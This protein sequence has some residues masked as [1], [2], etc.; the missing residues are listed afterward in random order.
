MIVLTEQAQSPAWLMI[1]SEEGRRKWILLFRISK[2]SSQ[3]WLWWEWV[4]VLIKSLAS[5]APNDVLMG[6]IK[7]KN[8]HNNNPLLPAYCPHLALS[9]LSWHFIAFICFSSRNTWIG[10]HCIYQG[11]QLEKIGPGEPQLSPSF[12][13]ARLSLEW[14]WVFQV[15]GDRQRQ[16]REKRR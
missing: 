1:R 6:S 3:S 10:L 13:S 16:Q 14:C 11:F 15:D 4:F 9:S 8:S 2:R 5:K 7:T 12:W